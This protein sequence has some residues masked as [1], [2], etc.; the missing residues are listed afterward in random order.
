LPADAPKG[1]PELG[2]VHDRAYTRRALQ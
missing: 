1:L 2:E